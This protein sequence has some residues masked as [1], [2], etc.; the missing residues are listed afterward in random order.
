MSCKCFGGAVLKRKRSSSGQ[1]SHDFDGNL[2]ENVRGLSYNELRSATNNFHA[3]NKIGRGG[4]GIVYKGTLKNGKQVAVK[5]LSARSKQGVREFLNEINTISNVR[6]PNLVELIGCC[7]QGADRIL[8]YEFVENNS[9][10]RALLGAR[11]KTIR[12]D[13]E[14]R[15]AICLGI[16][17]GLTFLHEE[18]NPHIVH[19][20]IKASNILLDGDL[21][22]KIGDF[23]LAKLFPDNIT[24]ISTRIAGTTFGVLILEIV[25]GRSSAR[26]NW[27]GTEKFLLEWAWQL[28]EEGRLLELVDPELGDYPEEEILRYMKVAFFCTQAASSRRPL[29]GQVLDMLSRN[30]R[31]NEKQL[32][33]PGFFNNSGGLGG[34]SSSKKSCADSS[35]YNMSSVPD[36]ITQ[37]MP[38]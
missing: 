26:E 38:R 20:D 13:W 37:V 16:A 27:G 24:H 6:H 25:G 3:S 28:H 33:A 5:T 19:R 21:N 36:T 30:I 12:L 15:K 22:A 10:D 23:G 31:L 34:P 8:V 4:F 2:P 18:L 7:V 14:K 1:T 32:T 9:L 35:T 29:M 17:R 11:D